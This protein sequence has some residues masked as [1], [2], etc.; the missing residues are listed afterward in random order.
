MIV[1]AI[2]YFTVGGGGQHTAHMPLN[3]MRKI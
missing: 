2:V 1:L 3:T